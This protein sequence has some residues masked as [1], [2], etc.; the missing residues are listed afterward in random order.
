MEPTKPP[1]W[2]EELRSL[3]VPPYEDPAPAKAKDSDQAK[4][5]RKTASARLRRIGLDP[6]FGG[7]K[8]G[9]LGAEGV[10]I[11]VT[12]AV[13]GVSRKGVLGLNLPTLDSPAP[14]ARPRSVR[15]D[16]IEYLVG[17]NIHRYGR[18][19]ERLDFQRLSEGSE[20][21]S[22]LYAALWPILGAGSQRASLIVGLPIQVLLDGRQAEETENKL[23]SWLLAEHSF[24]I[25]GEPVQLTVDQVRVVP[26]VMGTYYAC[27][28]EDSSPLADADASVGIAD[29]GFNTIDLIGVEGGETVSRFTSGNTLGMRRSAEIVANTVREGLGVDLSLHQADDMVV[30]ASSGEPVVVA[31]SGGST[32]VTTMVRQALDTTA[33]SVCTFIERSWGNGRQFRHLLLAGGGSRVLREYLVHLY[34][35]AVMVRDPIT[36]NAR[37]LAQWASRAF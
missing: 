32:D 22:L 24:E 7:F 6:G 10:R 9:E 35:D 19:V 26:Q 28:A 31:Q 3:G 17:A 36:S 15:Y 12:P 33:S 27:L 34:P 13:V 14:S 23:R 25:N 37:G 30:R 2:K 1:R 18:P 11:E 8:V 20:L 5:G 16:G 4:A 29:I 21:R